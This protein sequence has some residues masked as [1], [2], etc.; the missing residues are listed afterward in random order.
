MDPI[1]AALLEAAP[2]LAASLV[3]SAVKDAYLAVK[4]IVRRK[5]GRGSPLEKAIERAE[6]QPAAKDDN[7]LVLGR[8]IAAVG[9][10]ADA[11]LISAAR[12][13]AEALKAE[14]IGTSAIKGI[15]ITVSGGV[16]QGIMGATNVR[17]ENLSFGSPPK[18]RED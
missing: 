11:D 6:A 3:T 9:A 7:A 15:E 1:T 13:L 10:A 4:T 14:G 17:I 16:A 8:E 5:W 12:K 2:A 18:P